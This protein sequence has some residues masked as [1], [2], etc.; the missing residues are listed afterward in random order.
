MNHCSFC[1]RSAERVD[2]LVAGPGVYICNECVSL[3]AATIA[4]KPAGLT[5]A[6]PVWKG[7]DD[8]A[9]LAHLPRIEAIRHQ[10]D[11]DLR[12]WVGE[13]RRRGISWDRVGESLGMRR[14]SAWERFS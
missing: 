2:T 7:I 6:T 9:L 5:R 12:T 4:N 3:C 8:E 11:D 1:R 14:Q 13:A 10:V